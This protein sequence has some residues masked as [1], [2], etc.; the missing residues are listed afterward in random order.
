MGRSCCGPISTPIDD[1]SL[2]MTAKAE[3]VTEYEDDITKMDLTPADRRRAHR[4]FM[5]HDHQILRGRWTNFDIVAPGVFRS[6]QPDAARYAAFAAQGGRSVLNLR[7]VSRSAFYLYTKEGCDAAGLTLY[8]VGKLSARRAP[9]R[10]SLLEVFNVFDQAERGL[11][12]HC[13]SGA[14]RTGLVSTFYLIDQCHEAVA[15]ARRHLSSK[16]LHFSWSHSGIL[17]LLVNDVAQMEGRKSLRDYIRD[18]Y[19]ADDL[20]ARYQ[21][22]GLKAPG[23]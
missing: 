10:E 6:N 13:K 5:W 22:Y 15:T 11:L 18:D 2:E 4:Q 3:P 16:Y 19:D 23:S 21:K 12:M 8:N 17:D 7:G 9:N 14:D 20:T 1:P